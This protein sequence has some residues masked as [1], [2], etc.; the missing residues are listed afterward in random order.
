[1]K[2]DKRYYLGITLFGYSFVPYIFT[3]LI[4]PFFPISNVKAVSIVPYLFTEIAL[5]LNFVEKYG[6]AILMGLLVIGDI[7]F[8]MSFFVLG[9]EFWARINLLF[10]WPGSTATEGNPE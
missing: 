5:M 6:H 1:M 9:G 7:L 10:K 8:I 3:F 4:L 2:K